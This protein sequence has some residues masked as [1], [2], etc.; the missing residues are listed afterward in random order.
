[1]AVVTT[2]GPPATSTD[3]IL[4]TGLGI[5]SWNYAF[6]NISTQTTPATQTIYAV[7]VPL[8]VG[9]VVTNVLLDTE[10]AGAGTTPTNFFVG[11]ASATTVLGQ[12][13]DLKASAALT[14]QAI[15]TY[16]LAAP[17][18]ITTSGLYYVLILQNGV[19]GTTV[20]LLG[21]AGGRQVVG[22]NFL[23]A[24]AGTGQTALPANQGAITLSAGGT[25][26][27][28]WAGVS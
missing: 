9:Q 10:V 18:T 20:N 4:R 28:Y 25:P 12:S 14:T 3:E 6:T 17:V 21:R 19:F 7:G 22:A 2:S 23:Y 8:R 26:L 5:V 13:A 1:M 16:A 11:I 27:A 24:T 15:G